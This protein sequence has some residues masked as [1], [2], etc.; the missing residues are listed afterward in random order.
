[1]IDPEDKEEGNPTPV[2]IEEVKIEEVRDP[3]PTPEIEL[4]NRPHVSHEPEI[5][6][7]DPNRYNTG[8]STSPEDRE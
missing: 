1:M 7:V 4:Q 6:Q 5:I 3:I 8:G 2:D